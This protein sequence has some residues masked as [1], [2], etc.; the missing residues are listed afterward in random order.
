MAKKKNDLTLEEKLQQALVP[1]E[2]QSYPLP[3]NW[4]WTRLG[5]IATL[6]TGN[7]INAKKKEEKYK[8]QNTGLNFIG[9]KDVSFDNVIDYNNGVKITD[10]EKFKVAPKNTTLLCIEGGSSGRK[11]GFT[12]E[13]ICFGNKLC[14]FKTNNIES[15]IIY[16]FLQTNLFASEFNDK[17]HGLIGG[18]SVTEL[19]DIVISLPPIDE[20]KRIV[21]R[22]ESLFEKLDRAKELL[23]EALDSFEGR[24]SAILYKAFSGELTQNWRQENGIS[25]DSWEEISLNNLCSS[26]KYGTSKKSKPFGEVVVIRMGNLQRG[27][28]D[29]K[30]VVYTDDEEDI[31]K[32]L[33]T[34]GD[35]LFNRTNSSELVGKTSIFRGEFPA[36][37]AGYLIKLD[38]NRALVNGE[39]LNYYMNSIFAKKYCNKV[40][41]DG[42]NQSNINAKK[43]GVFKVKVPSKKEQEE[44]VSVIK[45]IFLQER[46]SEKLLEQSIDQI[47]LIKKSILAR[48]FRGELGTNRADEESALELLKKAVRD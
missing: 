43:I 6:Y 30:D 39:Y 13:D 18:V 40:K 20:Q 4:V 29:W 10:Y 15:K 25:L 3:D 11:M 16:Y 12:A 1:K 32:Y 9:T 46:K 17:R 31:K 28:V 37:Y 24:R 38:Y 2:E 48:A 42:V 41:T 35:V 44:I 5:A 27:E 22:I 23:Q 36:I 45:S 47:D 8:N 19:A 21:E 14:A 26:L 7:S 33:L 34:E